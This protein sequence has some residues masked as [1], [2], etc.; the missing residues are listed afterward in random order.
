MLVEPAKPPCF[1]SLLGVAAAALKAQRP[2]FVGL[3]PARPK[4]VPTLFGKPYPWQQEQAKCC[5]RDKHITVARDKRRRLRSS[6]RSLSVWWPTRYLQ[7][8]ATQM[9]MTKESTYA[10]SSNKHNEVR[11]MFVSREMFD[12]PSG[13]KPMTWMCISQREKE[14]KQHVIMAPAFTAKSRLQNAV[15]S[16]DVGETLSSLNKV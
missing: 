3:P 9:V 5:L 13:I 14:K 15:V 7:G 1:G 10:S 4:K 6:E 2:F 8:M 16:E 12:R 11:E